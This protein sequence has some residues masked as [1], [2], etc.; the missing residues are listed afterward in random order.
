MTYYMEHPE[1]GRTTAYDTGEVG[2][3]EKLGWKRM[4][5]GALVSG[6][7]AKPKEV[8][9]ETVA[10]QARDAGDDDVQ[11]DREALAA[12]YKARFGKAPHHK[13]SA[14]KIAEALKAGE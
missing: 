3:L 8:K 4:P 12:E 1:H 2:R 11:P 10:P 6:A 7:W 14:E 5:E 13:L 9:R